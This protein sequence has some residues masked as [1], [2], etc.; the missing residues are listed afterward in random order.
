MGGPMARHIPDK[1]DDQPAN[2]PPG[3]HPDPHGEAPLRWWDGSQW[4]G[5]T[6]AAPDVTGKTGSSFSFTSLLVTA[7]VVLVAVAALASFAADNESPEPRERTTP[8][9]PSTHTVLYEVEGS[10]DYAAVTM[11]TPTGTRQINP[12]IPMTR[13]DSG[14][15]GLEM[16]VERGESLYL[17]AQNQRGSGTIVCRI[18]V[19]GRVISENE[20]S[21]G[22]TIAS[23]NGQAE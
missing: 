14:E 19:D 21:G 9:A 4:T 6:A 20:S 22:H 3:W 2:P 15:R 5:H 17:S 16:T 11:R 8:T 23:C 7:G 18:S 1:D 13:T 10:T 12:D